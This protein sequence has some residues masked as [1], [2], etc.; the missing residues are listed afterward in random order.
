MEAM[1]AL[2]YLRGYV[3]LFA[4]L[5][6]E[7]LTPMAA[8]STLQQHPA[9]H[10][11]LFRGMTVEGLHVLIAGRAA[12]LEKHPAKGM[13]TRAELGPGDVFGETS[14]VE[15]GT[16]GATIK[17][18]EDCVVLVIPQTAFREALQ[19]DEP[20]AVRVNQLI[21]SRKPAAAPANATPA[22]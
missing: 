10:T 17:S 8:A 6:D 5:S 11:I 12:V 19:R 21:A 16:A 15:L 3:P 2:T 18:V 7:L 22:A 13:I 1:D 14:I 9:G 20:F 4:G